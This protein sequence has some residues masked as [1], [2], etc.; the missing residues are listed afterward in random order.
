MAGSPSAEDGGLRA[1]LLD[2]V[3]DGDRFR[4]AQLERLGRRVADQPGELG[5]LVAQPVAVELVVVLL[6]AWIV[7]RR[8][9]DGMNV[10]EGAQQAM[11]TTPTQDVDAIITDIYSSTQADT[12]T[13][14]NASP[15]DFSDLTK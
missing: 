12:Q 11:P 13:T 4:G 10:E 15:A 8:S 7:F 3:G 6:G 5:Q 1:G 9:D 2:D 14:V